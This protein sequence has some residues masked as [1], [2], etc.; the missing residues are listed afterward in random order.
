VTAT[1]TNTATPTPTPTCLGGGNGLT[2]GF[3]HN[4][5]GQ[6]ALTSGDLCALNAL[7]LRNANGT[8][9]DPIAGCPNPTAAQLKAGKTALSD[10]LIGANAT[11]M[12]NMLS[13]QLA[14]M[15]LNV[16]QP[17][18]NA[19]VDG[20]ALVFAGTA[21]SGCSVPGLSGTGLITVNDLMSA[22]NSAS[23]Y[24]LASYPDTTASGAAR[25]CQEFMKTALDRANNNQNFLV[26]C[27]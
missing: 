4:K 11:N 13:A 22:A 20:N 14:A 26:P 8:A 23:N 16:I 2:L 25:T 5:N 19:S 12:A 21:P 24:S 15:K 6:A 17:I 7:N 27:R 3:W 10:W 9:F 18:N 1:S